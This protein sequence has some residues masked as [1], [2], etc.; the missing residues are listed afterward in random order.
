MGGYYYKG[1]VEEG[2]PGSRGRHCQDAADDGR[3][4]FSKKYS[5]ICQ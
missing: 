3:N 2:F 5:N 1:I 4:S